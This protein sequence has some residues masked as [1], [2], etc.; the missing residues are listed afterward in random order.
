[1]MNDEMTGAIDTLEWELD[2]E[3]V[4]AEGLEA[5]LPPRSFGA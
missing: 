4:E 2:Q 5:A 1:M 3:T